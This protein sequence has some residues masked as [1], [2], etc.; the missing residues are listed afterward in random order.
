ML[1][2]AIEAHTTALLSVTSLLY[3]PLRSNPLFMAIR[4][5]TGLPPLKPSSGLIPKYSTK[6]QFATSVFPILQPFAT[7]ILCTACGLSRN[8][9]LIKLI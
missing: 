4:K 8:Y 1:E 2:I 7:S 6:I 3:K 5:K 9:R